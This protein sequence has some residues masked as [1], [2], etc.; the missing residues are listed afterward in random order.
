MTFGDALILLKTFKAQFA[1]GKDACPTRTGFIMSVPIFSWLS[2]VS[3]FSLY[4]FAQVI[5]DA[6][7]LLRGNDDSIA[8]DVV[9]LFSSEVISRET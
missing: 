4:W 8:N 9:Q 2:H 6:E 5:Y 3:V 1:Q 7:E